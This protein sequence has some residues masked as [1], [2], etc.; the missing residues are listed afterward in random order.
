MGMKKPGD[1]LVMMIVVNILLAK[2]Y[3]NDEVEE[4][5]RVC[6]ISIR[7]RKQVHVEF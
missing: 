2:Y 3:K 5:E 1:D 4:N 7:G 6:H